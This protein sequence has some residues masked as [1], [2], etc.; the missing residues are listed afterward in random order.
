MALRAAKGDEDS[1]PA[2]PPA[3]A[4]GSN[5]SRDRK[6]AV[7]FPPSATRVFNGVSHGATRHP[8]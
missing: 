7:V 4:R 3:D 5:P 2:V 6:G 1:R 8:R